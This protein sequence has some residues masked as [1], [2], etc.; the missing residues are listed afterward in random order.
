MEQETRNLLFLKLSIVRKMISKWLSVLYSCLN[1]TL[2]SSLL[3][4]KG[5]FLHFL[6]KTKTK[7]VKSNLNISLRNF[8]AKK[9]NVYRRKGWENVLKITIII[10]TYEIW[11]LYG[12]PQVYIQ[13][14]NETKR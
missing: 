8:K 1:S 14:K 5:I 12:V 3:L 13:Q 10:L 9:I 4:K 11:Q 7:K 6:S 2:V